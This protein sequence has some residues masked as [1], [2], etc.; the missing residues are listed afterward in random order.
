MHSYCHRQRT[1]HGLPLSKKQ[2]QNKNRWL[3]A[4]PLCD[5]LSQILMSNIFKHSCE[6]TTHRRTRIRE[7][8]QFVHSAF[9]QLQTLFC[10]WKS[11][12]KT[13][14]HIK[15]SSCGAFA[16]SLWL[17]AHGALQAS[18]WPLL[19]SVDKSR[20]EDSTRYS[21]LR[22]STQRSRVS[23]LRSAAKPPE[24]LPT[25]AGARWR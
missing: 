14:T 4:P 24:L 21:H 12:S 23:V 19:W 9:K 18:N 11:P 20:L 3:W 13:D 8:A 6:R 1:C 5:H 16:L 17:R 22:S 15:K 10:T 25:P 7:P 2:K